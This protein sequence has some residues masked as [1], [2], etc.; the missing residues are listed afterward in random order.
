MN[1]GTRPSMPAFRVVAG[2]LSLVANI[3]ALSTLNCSC[4]S[5]SF[6]CFAHKAM[7]DGTRPS[8]PAFRVV[9]GGLP[10]VVNIVCTREPNTSGLTFFASL[11]F[12]MIVFISSAFPFTVIINA[13][14]S[15]TFS[16][17]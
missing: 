11:S 10:L 6:S 4:V 7:N 14:S 5:S 1:D 8:M 2:E 9:A 12:F 16:V 17:E 13:S 3:V 15:L